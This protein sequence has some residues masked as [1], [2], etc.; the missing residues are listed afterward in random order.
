MQL[1]QYNGKDNKIMLAIVPA[2][3]FAINS[4]VFGSQYFSGFVFFLSATLASTVTLGFFFITCGAVAVLIKNRF[5]AERQAMQR[6]SLMILTFLIMSGLFLYAL[7]SGYASVSFFKYHFDEQRFAWAYFALG[8]VNIFLTLLME[9]IAR[10]QEWEAGWQE[11]AKLN[12]AI[13]KSQLDGL[14]SQVNPHF[15]FN[16]LNTLSSLIQEDET[17]AERFLD[18]MSK[19]YRY[20][21]RDDVQW[22]TLDAEL[23]FLRSYLHLL[24]ARFGEGLQVEVQVPEPTRQQGIAPRT[25]QVLIENAFSQNTI[26]KNQPLRIELSIN[27]KGDLI[28]RNN[29]QPKKNLGVADPE[30]SLDHLIAKY[31]LLK[32]PIVV[33]DSEPGFR[34]VCI[35]LIFQETNALS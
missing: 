9:G 32:Y 28:V 21:L 12:E 2:G 31:K 15:L 17:K 23:K 19:V 30:L 35:P 6:L 27:A 25:L 20:M 18:E 22:V 16:S 1:P 5:P 34:S 26:G 13:K 14:K 24:H 10:Y 7:F 29:V 33:D 8:I 3:A 4:I 11:T